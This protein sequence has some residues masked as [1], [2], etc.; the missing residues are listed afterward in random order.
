MWE[1][2]ER[3]ALMDNPEAFLFRTAMNVF[4][5]RSRRAR[6][7]LRRTIGGPRSEGRTRGGRGARPGRAGAAATHASRARSRGAH[8]LRGFELARGWPG[9]RDSVRHGADPTA[10]ARVAMKTAMEESRV[11]D[12][13]EVFEKS[14]RRYEPEGGS[15][16]RLVR[17]RDRKRRNQRIAAGVVGIAVFVAAV[18]V[19]TSVGS[20]DRTQTPAVPGGRGRI[21]RNRTVGCAQSQSW[22]AS[23]A[24]LRGTAA[25]HSGAGR[26]GPQLLDLALQ[27]VGVRRWTTD[28]GTTTSYGA[29]DR[30]TSYLDAPHRPGAELL[31][32]RGHRDRT[33]RPTSTSSASRPVRRDRGRQRRTACP[34]ALGR[35]RTI[36]TDRDRRATKRSSTG[37]MR[38]WRIQRRGC[39]QRMGG[40]RRSGR[41]CHPIL[42]LLRGDGRSAPCDPHL[43]V[44]SRQR[45]GTCS[46]LLAGPGWNRGR[47]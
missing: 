46:A 6:L 24:C 44:A 15:F 9:L 41:T 16:E 37:S 33:F 32:V 30:S 10:R 40:S 17:R 47:R 11:I 12:E 7:A 20:F 39:R 25:E 13:R 8:L 31:H 22:W 29:N 26:A 14:F 19:V 34:R 1:R 42:G 45:P 3:V 38:A 43:D 36:P 2:W 23:S 4:R 21:D 18:W 27:D 28:L 35:S 5:N